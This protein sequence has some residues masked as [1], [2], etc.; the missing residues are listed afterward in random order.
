MQ[1]VINHSPIRPES[2]KNALSCGTIASNRLRGS[3]HSA[4]TTTKTKAEQQQKP[5]K[6]P[7]ATMHVPV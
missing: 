7:V 1:D 6:Q 4:T 5:R 2:E 3:P